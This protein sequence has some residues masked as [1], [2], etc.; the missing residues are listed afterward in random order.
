MNQ[1]RLVELERQLRQSIGKH[2]RYLNLVAGRHGDFATLEDRIEIAEAVVAEPPMGVTQA[3]FE[4]LC[5]RR[6]ER[7]VVMEDVEL[8][9]TPTGY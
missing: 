2:D 6:R 5:R 8:P 9:Y 4:R 1:D 3:Q 7:G